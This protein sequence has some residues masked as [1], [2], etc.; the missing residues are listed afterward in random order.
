MN[1]DCQH[2]TISQVTR[3][4]IMT[5]TATGAAVSSLVFGTGTIQPASN[6]IRDS[7]T[8]TMLI[9][10]L[11]KEIE[12][13]AAGLRTRFEIPLSYDGTA[14][15]NAIWTA[16]CSIPYGKTCSYA[17]LAEKA[18]YPG[19]WRAAG[20]AVHNNPIA[21]V[22]PCHRIIGTNGSLTGYAAGLERK[23]MLLE[24]ESQNTK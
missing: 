12:E 1:T 19:A 18:G 22:I 6:E 13:Y 14:F 5:A 16:L 20:N 3:F 10:E 2:C 7:E 4:G 11:F 8:A 21:L 15:Q 23:K 17:E 24:L 9:T